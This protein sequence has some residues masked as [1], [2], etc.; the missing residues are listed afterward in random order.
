TKEQPISSEKTPT[1]PKDPEKFKTLLH[2]DPKTS[3]QP[4]ATQR[5]PFFSEQ[6]KERALLKNISSKNSSPIR[7]KRVIEDRST[8]DRVDLQ[9]VRQRASRRH[10]ALKK[11][12]QIS[13]KT[14]EGA[15]AAESPILPL[16]IDPSKT[17]LS[18][19]PSLSPPM[20]QE[21]ILATVSIPPISS[22]DLQAEIFYLF[23]QM[24]GCMTVI[25]LCSGDSQTSMMLTGP[26]FE[27][28]VFFGSQVIIEEFSTAPK[29]FNVQLIGS[30]PAIALFEA[31]KNDL[32]AAFQ[33]GPYT[34]KVNRLEASL[35]KADRPSSHRKV[36]AADDFQDKEDREGGRKQ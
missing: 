28:S 27:H 17:L 12:K 30:L 5:R 14:I 32:L 33:N 21:T 15:V 10:Q 2:T 3:L 16:Q 18:Q 8:E 34:F 24:V 25:H 9:P 1:P 20:I 6:K 29:V 7:K 26:Q 11:D 22:S 36:R 13:R 23:D 31:S 35:A 19:I 4:D